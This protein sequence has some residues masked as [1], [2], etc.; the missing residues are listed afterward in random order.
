MHAAVR[1]LAHVQV[2]Q[3]LPLEY[4]LLSELEARDLNVP[5][6]RRRRRS[7]CT[8]ALVTSALAVRVVRSRD[9]LRVF[10]RSV[11]GDTDAVVMTAALQAGVMPAVSSLP[12][13]EDAPKEPVGEVDANGVPI[14]EFWVE[15]VNGWGSDWGL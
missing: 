15:G 14:E 6:Q 13:A 5:L 10:V 8:A 7:R 3:V 12:A 9:D 11:V 2:G 1:H 4:T